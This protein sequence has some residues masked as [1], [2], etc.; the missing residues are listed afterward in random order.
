MTAAMNKSAKTFAVVASVVT[1][2]AA[3]VVLALQAQADVPPYFPTR[4]RN[5]SDS[6]QAIVVVGRSRSSSYSTV[7]T[8]QKGSDG[9]WRAKFAAMA[10]RN[11]WAGWVWGSQR[12]QN[13]GTSPMGTYRITTG[14]GLKSNP[15]TK[16]SYRRVDSTDYWVGDRNDPRTYNLFE[17]Y[18][19]AQRTWRISQAERLAVYPTQYEH[20]A[21]IDF[22]RPAASSVTWNSTNSEYVTSKPVNTTRGSA[23]FLHINGAGSTAGCVSVGRTNMI[24]V[25]KWLDPAQKPRIAMAPLADIGLV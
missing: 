11:G 15:G 13:T 21:V 8:Y 10:A 24:N 2:L 25:L 9:V 14:F 20:A 17:P 6:R 23:I 19:S 18:A 1:L 12:V 7:Y 3:G 16:L 5:I 22:N 4:L